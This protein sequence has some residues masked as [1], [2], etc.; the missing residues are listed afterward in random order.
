MFTYNKSVMNDLKL[1]PPILI[2]QQPYR[3]INFTGWKK[4][5]G[6]FHALP[7]FYRYYREPINANNNSLDPPC[8]HSRCHCRNRAQ[9]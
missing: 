6:H 2:R 3:T 1:Q 7:S 5:G 4:K 9:R 8:R